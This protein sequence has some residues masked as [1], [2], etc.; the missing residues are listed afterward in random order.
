[1]SNL[2]GIFV[3]A[4]ILV[5]VM[6]LHA[7][8]KEMSVTVK[9]TQVRQ[10]PSFMGKVLATLVYGDRVEVSEE[11]RGW[12]R[13]AIPGGRG[14]GWV[15]LSALTNKKIVMKAGSKDVEKSASSSEV[16]LA[17][18]GFNEEV[19]AK[20]KS[21]KNLDYTWIDRMETF[22]FPPEELAAF[23]DEAGLSLGGAE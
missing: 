11:K 2:R 16:A 4:F 14:K 18:K 23:M 21:D 20:Y 12:A 15:N 7:A 22:V 9:E 6:N 5:A 13:I 1:M 17:G 10:S 8:D 19:E 3:Y